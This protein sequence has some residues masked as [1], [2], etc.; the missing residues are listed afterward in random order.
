MVLVFFMVMTYAQRGYCF[1]AV[2]V[3]FQCCGLVPHQCCFRACQGCF[4]AVLVWHECCFQCGFSV[5]FVL[6]QCRFSATMA[7]V[8]FQ[9]RIGSVAMLFQLRVG[10]VSVLPL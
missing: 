2:S 1:H 3:L 6:F 7:A 8:L 5:A 4:N 10:A 9:C